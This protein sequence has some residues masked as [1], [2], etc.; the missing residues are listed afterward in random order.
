[1]KILHLTHDHCALDD[2]IFYRESRSLAKSHEVMI[3]CRHMTDM[4][5]TPVKEEYRDRVNIKQYNSAEIG[6]KAVFFQY[7]LG[8]N[9][10]NINEALEETARFSPDVLHVH[11]PLAFCAALRIKKVSPKIKIIVDLHENWEKAYHGGIKAIALNKALSSCLKKVLKNADGLIAADPRTLVRSKKFF[12]NGVSCVIENRPLPFSGDL[13]DSKFLKKEKVI[14]HEGTLK[15]HIGLKDITKT[16]EILKKRGE[17]DFKLRI[18]GNI[19]DPEKKWLDKTIREKSLQ[20]MVE[21]SGFVKYEN[22]RTH[23]EE[24]LIGLIMLDPAV[25]N[26]HFGSTNKLWNY[27]AAG[28]YIISYDTGS[29]TETIE[30][31][32]AGKVLRNSNPEEAADEILRI[33]NNPELL[34]KTCRNNRKLALQSSFNWL[35]EEKK[36]NDFYKKLM[37]MN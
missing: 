8:F 23:E 18:L 15:F 19:P 9:A 28:L 5:G 29:E 13:P 24:A 2:R 35:F 22:L 12:K 11:D 32:K 1:M 31:N 10:P 6:S 16:I 26:N 4:G 27:F 37:D 25:P 36:L 20:D 33:S 34:E 14:I 7:L 3:L 17:K 21:I 30:K